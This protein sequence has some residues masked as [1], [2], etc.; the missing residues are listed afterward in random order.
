MKYSSRNKR[1]KN[2]SNDSS[3][4]IGHI[5]GLIYFDVDL[6][7][8]FIKSC[9]FEY[10]YPTHLK[11]V[12]RSWIDD[13]IRKNLKVLQ[14]NCRR[15]FDHT[16]GISHTFS[17]SDNWKNNNYNDLFKWGTNIFDN[18]HANTKT[19]WMYAKWRILCRWIIYGDR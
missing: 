3:L 9:K 7:M 11:W 2:M 4:R 17:A 15:W 12:S 14:T 19:I 18:N 1:F 8:L 13:F 6:S 10:H 5:R 16:S